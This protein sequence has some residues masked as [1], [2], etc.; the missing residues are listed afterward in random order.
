MKKKQKKNT[1]T[2]FLVED[3]I[4]NQFDLIEHKK[5]PT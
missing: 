3:I 2:T 4:R 5:I 1:A